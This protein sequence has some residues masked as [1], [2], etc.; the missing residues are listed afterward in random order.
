MNDGLRAGFHSHAVY[1]ILIARKESRIRQL[2]TFRYFNKKILIILNTSLEQCIIN[3]QNRK[4]NLGKEFVVK[5]YN[6][7]ETPTLDEGWDLIIYYENDDQVL[8][9]LKDFLNG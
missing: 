6:Q 5:N 9:E 2:K 1:D 4:K 7:I 8:K 3:D